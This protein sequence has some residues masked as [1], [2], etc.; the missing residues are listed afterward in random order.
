MR[1]IKTILL[2]LVSLNLFSQKLTCD[3]IMRFTLPEIYSEITKKHDYTIAE[4]KCFATKLSDY[5]KTKGIK[6]VL[7][8][9]GMFQTPCLKCL[10]NNVGFETYDFSSDDILFENVDTFIS[11]YNSNME[12]LIPTEKLDKIKSSQNIT[13]KVFTS[14]LFGTS[15]VVV[16][17][18]SDTLLNFKIYNVDL[19]QLFN[20]DLKYL[21]VFITDSLHESILGKYKYV[22]IKNIGAI[23]N[24]GKQGVPK[25]YVTFDFGEMPDRLEVCW[26][27]ILD[28]RYYLTVPIKRN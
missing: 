15:K 26:C 28:R 1:L 5:D 11:I 17:E 23:I 9:S 13:D 16:E 2:L 10:Y 7:T 27:S 6:R 14:I 8:Y 21:N 24:V 19:E 18:I 25:I 3:R 12:K 4:C 20:N 22:E